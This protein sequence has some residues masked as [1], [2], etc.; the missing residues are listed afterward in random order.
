LA[1]A[2]P[3]RGLTPLALFGPADA[4]ARQAFQKAY[5]QCRQAVDLPL[6]ELVSLLA[7]SRAY[8]GNDSGVTHL[9]ARLCPTLALFGP[10]DPRVWRPLGPR[11]ETLAAPGGRMEELDFALVL[12]ALLELLRIRS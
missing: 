11:V 12:S 6:R 5:P 3:D 4:A 10:S 2:A 1:R 9:A 7:A 8:V